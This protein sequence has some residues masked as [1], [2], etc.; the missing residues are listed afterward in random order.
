MSILS[1]L[2]SSS[3]SKGTKASY[4]YQ[5]G[6][7]PTSVT[8]VTSKEYNL[9]ECPRCHALN[10][11]LQRRQA[12]KCNKCGLSMESVKQPHMGA[13]GEMLVWDDGA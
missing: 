10:D 6:D 5:V 1:K 9:T 4:D 12:M 8:G 13:P 2:F 3:N 11:N 7:V